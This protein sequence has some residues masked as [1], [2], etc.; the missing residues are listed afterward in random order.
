METHR[1]QSFRPA[2]EVLAS[3]KLNTK[4]AKR[5]MENVIVLLC[6]IY[7]FCKARCL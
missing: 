3:E 4:L 5:R 7:W 2:N 6:F 1:V